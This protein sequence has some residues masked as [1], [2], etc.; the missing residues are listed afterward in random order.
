M[1]KLLVIGGI[2][3]AI[4]ALLLGYLALTL[5]MAGQEGVVLKTDKEVYVKG[6][7]VKV[8]LVNLREGPVWFGSVYRVEYYNGSA[9]VVSDELTPDIFTA[10]L[11]ILQPGQSTEWTIPLDDA[12]L[13]KYRVVKEV[14][15]DDSG[16]E[17][18][19]VHAYFE[20]KD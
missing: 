19:E 18:L 1:P 7:V 5:Y 6:E 15:L 20:V 12:A 8:K 11:R 13:G 16:K 17:R 10:E 4:A 14:W 2:F 9:W 3:F